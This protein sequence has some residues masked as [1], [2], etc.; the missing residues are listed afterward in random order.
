MDAQEIIATLLQQQKEQQSTLLQQH[1]EM[2]ASREAAMLKLT[3]NF[4]EKL[5]AAKEELQRSKATNASL[6]T[7]LLIAQERYNLRGA[8]EA[9][10]K[11]VSGKWSESMTGAIRG[12]MQTPEIRRKVECVAE[13]AQCRLTEYERVFSTLPDALSKFIHTNPVG[14]TIVDPRVDSSKSGLSRAQRAA[15]LGTILAAGHEVLVIDEMERPVL[16]Y[17][18][19]CLK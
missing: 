3:N 7:R 17:H 14:V 16:E 18:D 5:N 1:K 8:V 15:C 9:A 6:V 12:A 19:S 10:A 4:N 2:Y 11:D 13:I